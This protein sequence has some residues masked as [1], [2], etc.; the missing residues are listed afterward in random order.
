MPAALSTSGLTHEQCAHFAAQRNYEVFA[1]QSQGYCFLGNLADVAQMKTR[2]FDAKCSTTPCA[3]VDG[4]GCIGM[5]NKVYA[6]G[7]LPCDAPITAH[8]PV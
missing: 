1:L 6:I 7:A 3:Q 8:M 2:L 4:V 5:V